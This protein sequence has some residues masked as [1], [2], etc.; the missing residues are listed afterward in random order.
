[1]ALLGQEGVSNAIRTNRTSLFVAPTMITNFCGSG[2]VFAACVTI[3]ALP[4]E[5]FLKF[6]LLLSRCPETLVRLGVV[7]ADACLWKDV[8]I[9]ASIIESR[10]V[11]FGPVTS[12][13][14]VMG[15]PN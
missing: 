9:N 2:Q 1:M 7:G 4:D 8:R 13:M 11:D 5:V 10:G 15:R 14:P 12:D 6:R 3:H